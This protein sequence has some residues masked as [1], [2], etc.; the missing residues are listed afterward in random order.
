MTI[1]ID[2]VAPPFSGHLNPLI[3][4][5]RPLVHKNFE[6]RFITGPQKVQM[7]RDMGFQAIPL[8][9]DRPDVMENI[10]NTSKAVGSNPF[11]LSKQLKENL[12]ILPRV[13]QELELLVTQNNTD[14]VVADFVAVP[15][16]L[17]CEEKNIPWITTMPT[18]FALETRQGTPSY[19]GGLT[20]KRSYTSNIRD[21]IGRKIVRSFKWL[22]DCWF[23][24][25]FKALNFKIYRSDGTEGAYSPHA[26]LG[27]GLESFEFARDWPKQFKFI[28]PCCFSPETVADI[29]IPFAQYDKAVLVTLGTHLEWAKSNLIREVEDLAA[30]FPKVLFIIS[31]GRPQSCS[32]M[33]SRKSNVLAF[34]YIPYS[35]YLRRFDAVIHHGGAGIT[36]NCIKYMKPCLVVPHD[37]DQFD[38]AARIE[39]QRIGLK[40]K[41]IG[42]A[43]AV[44]KLSDILADN[45]FIQLRALSNDMEKHSPSS[46]LEMEIYRLLHGARE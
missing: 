4:L 6:I 7:L 38:F 25:E 27:L 19:L 42:S 33:D 12:A 26:I 5:A 41:R 9:E 28:G 43:E 37:Y 20:Y 32:I 14:I 1:K 45:R 16:G 40:V 39:Y 11:F 30:Y 29:E 2:F 10:A 13:K 46:E 35:Q 22:V 21:F 36:Y 44:E 15:V 31:F 18:P 24:Q 8:L 23:K 17:V 3:E 34:P